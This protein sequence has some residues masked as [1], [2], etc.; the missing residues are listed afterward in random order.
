VKPSSREIN[1]MSLFRSVLIPMT[2]CVIGLLTTPTHA[3]LEFQATFTEQWF[4]ATGANGPNS[5][6]DTESDLWSLTLTGSSPYAAG[7]QIQSVVINFDGNV[8]FDVT[9]G[10]GG[11][12]GAYDFL[13]LGSSSAVLAATP[14]VADGDQTL[15]LN[16]TS[17]GVG[18]SL[19][20]EI[21]VDNSNAVVRG[22]NG[23]GSNHDM[24]GATVDVS[25][26][27]N[28][29]NRSATFTFGDGPGH[30]SRS[31]AASGEILATPEPL[32]LIVW[33]ILSVLGFG[34]VR[35]KRRR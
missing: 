33:S 27:D 1:I 23:S 3:A 12:D 29:V 19:D 30:P 34:L 31:S 20:F 28:G 22:T 24:R 18:D 17:F 10:G 11:F 4:S 16:F 7:V 6:V 26:I 15:A 8:Y 14:T 35:M 13:D 32:S 21:D 5:N 9:A 2:A 25:Y